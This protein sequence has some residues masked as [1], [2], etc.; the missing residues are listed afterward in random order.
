LVWKSCRESPL[1]RPRYRWKENIKMKVMYTQSEHL[2]QTA[3]SHVHWKV[4]KLLANS[5]LAVDLQLARCEID[6]LESCLV[7]SGFHT[8]NCLEDEFAIHCSICM[9]KTVLSLHVVSLWNCCPEW[10]RNKCADGGKEQYL[11]YLHKYNLHAYISHNW[12][13]RRI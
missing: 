13:L 9:A 4:C 12:L 1:E 3:C 7:F 10:G 8:C 2:F 6:T 5:W 11:Q